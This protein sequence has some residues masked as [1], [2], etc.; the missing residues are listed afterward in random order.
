MKVK[1]GDTVKWRGGFG[2]DE[3]KLA[4]VNGLSV[5]T[6]AR[7]KYGDQVEEA[8]ESLVAQNRVVFD[9]DSGHWAYSDQI[10]LIEQTE[11]LVTRQTITHQQTYLDLSHQHRDLQLL[12]ENYDTDDQDT[13]DKY[14]MAEDAL[15]ATLRDSV[16]ASFLT[17][18]NKKQLLYICS[19]CSTFRPF[20]PHSFLGLLGLAYQ[21]VESG[22]GG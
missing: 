10:E 20:Q 12:G 16:T 13:R 1:I 21:E 7:D 3:P 8:D 2:N 5:T 4:V 15:K 18:L 11:E 17:K 19:L 6:I 14:H 22:Q 9:L